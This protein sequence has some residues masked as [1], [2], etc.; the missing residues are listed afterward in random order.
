MNIRDFL[1]VVSLI[2]NLLVTAAF[3]YAV[4]T[5]PPTTGVQ[6]AA[7]K[8]TAR[9]RAPRPQFVTQ[10]LTVTNTV[11]LDWRSIES[12][13]YREYIARLK[14]AGCPWETIKDIIIADVNRL[15]APKIAA[16]QPPR[17]A[18]PNYWERPSRGSGARRRRALAPDPGNR[19]GEEGAARG[20]PRDRLSGGDSGH[21]RPSSIAGHAV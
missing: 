6:T 9:D 12:E 16:L 17:R 10:T 5:R 20:A 21:V 1:L 3:G 15:Y 4:F 18:Q 14:A 8:L 7:A 13:D 19:P 2:L 11:P